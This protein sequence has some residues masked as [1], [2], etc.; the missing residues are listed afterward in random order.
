MMTAAAMSENP[1]RYVSI[2]PI[3]FFAF[4]FPSDLITA[5]V[6]AANSFA[7]VSSRFQSGIPVSFAGIQ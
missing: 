1:G 3:T 5:S 2:A 4:R 7:S 6:R